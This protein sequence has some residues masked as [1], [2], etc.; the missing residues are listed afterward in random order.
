MPAIWRKGE[1]GGKRPV[2]LGGAGPLSGSLV[3]R[4]RQGRTKQVGKMNEN[5]TPKGGRL[6]KLP[7]GSL[8]LSL[9]HHAAS[10]SGGVGLLVL[11]RD[12]LTLKQF[13]SDLVAAWMAV[14][15]PI[16]EFFFGWLDLWLHIHVPRALHDYL[17]VGGILY[18][19]SFRAEALFR[20]G[21]KHLEHALEPVNIQRLQLTSEPRAAGIIFYGLEF[22]DLAV[23][24]TV[25]GATELLL[26]SGEVR[27]VGRGEMVIPLLRLSLRDQ[28]SIERV[29]LTHDVENNSIPAGGSV[30]FQITVKNPPR[31]VVDLEMTFERGVDDRRSSS[32]I[33][34][35][36]IVQLSDTTQQQPHAG[37]RLRGVNGSDIRN[38]LLRF[39]AM[40]LGWP[41]YL[42]Y[43]TVEA[44]LRDWRLSQV[45]LEN[46]YFYLFSPLI[47]FLVLVLA[48]YFLFWVE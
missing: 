42:L 2:T 17:I 47:Y 19:G 41:V 12:L 39:V 8:W 43:Y 3:G 40:A 22:Y 20:V 24:R 27:N 34:A 31:D 23:E 30:P 25:S 7:T 32:G 18:F 11:F 28:R 35:Q 29:V 5:G 4:S 46:F 9:Y 45:S 38:E 37:W 26:V 48:N 14:V 21:T 15:R 16:S 13:F 6:R 1:R 33:A 36:T 44:R 10:I